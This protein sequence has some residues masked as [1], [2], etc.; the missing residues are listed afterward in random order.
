VDVFDG[1]RAPTGP[2]DGII[3]G[4]VA[5]P[6]ESSHDVATVRSL[7]L[8]QLLETPVRAGLNVIAFKVL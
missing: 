8:M 4:L 7:H 5:D 3:L 6:A 2:N 1:A